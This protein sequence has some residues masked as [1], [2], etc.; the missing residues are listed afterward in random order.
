MAARGGAPLGPRGSGGPRGRT[1]P[2][3]GVHVALPG[4]RRGILVTASPGPHVA[5]VPSLGAAATRG[6]A[7]VRGLATG[8]SLSCPRPLA[9]PWRTRAASR[10]RIV[11]PGLGTDVTTAPVGAR[12]SSGSGAPP[13]RV[14]GPSATA[15]SR[16]GT[17][18]AGGR[19]TPVTASA[20]STK[21]H[22]LAV[23][24]VGGACRTAPSLCGTV[25]PLAR[26]G[27]V[28]ILLGVLT[29]QAGKTNGCC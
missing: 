4:P 12:P 15:F 3:L 11:A 8:P 13:A 17:R 6:R 1:G 19:P 21:L 5:T 29:L 22:R 23:L 10:G 27:A 14:G 26:R 9:R 16:G 20:P 28:H 2:G 25:V 24:A 18:G 7:C